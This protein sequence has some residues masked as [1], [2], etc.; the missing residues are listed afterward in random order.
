SDATN[1]CAWLTKKE[2]TEGRLPR[3]SSYRLPTDAGWSYAVGI[4]DQETGSTPR[5]KNILNHNPN[6]DTKLRG[7]YPWGTQFPPPKRAGNYAD[8]T[9]KAKFPRFETIPGYEDGYVSTAPVGSFTANRLG[10][11]DLGGNV[12]EWCDDWYDGRKIL[13]TLRGVAYN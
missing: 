12:F 13:R 3:D 1:F 4:G 10:I 11:F 9:L 6:A 2:Q 8:A 5:E 7:V